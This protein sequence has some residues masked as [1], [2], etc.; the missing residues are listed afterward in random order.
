[1]LN[2]CFIRGVSKSLTSRTK[3]KEHLLIMM[4]QGQKGLWT[5]ICVKYNL[6]NRKIVDSMAILLQSV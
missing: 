4:Y 2:F 1:M 5:I 6:Q 3:H